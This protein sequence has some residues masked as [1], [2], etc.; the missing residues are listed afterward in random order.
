MAIAAAG[1]RG[2]GPVDESSPRAADL[3]GL[4]EPPSSGSEVRPLTLRLGVAG[5][6][7]RLLIEGPFSVSRLSRSDLLFLQDPGSL[8]PP[9][10]PVAGF[11]RIGEDVVVLLRTSDLAALARQRIGG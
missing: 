4:S 3:L 5:Q 2:L 10:P 1:V 8:G 7:V 6:E 11:A 9:P